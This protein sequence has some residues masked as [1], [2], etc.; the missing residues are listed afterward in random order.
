M[1]GVRIR[2]LVGSIYQ[3]FIGLLAVFQAD[4]I[5]IQLQ[6]RSL[7]AGQVIVILGQ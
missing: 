5:R 2:W 7:F 3:G 4:L 1:L 6:K